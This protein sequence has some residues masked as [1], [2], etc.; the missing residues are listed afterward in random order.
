MGERY[1]W[2]KD[3]GHDY[4]RSNWG[5]S[6][7]TAAKAAPAAASHAAAAVGHHPAPG[8]KGPTDPSQMYL[9]PTMLQHGQSRGVLPKV[10]A[11]TQMSIPGVSMPGM[12]TMK[13]YAPAA[14]AGAKIAYDYKK[15]GKIPASEDVSGAIGKIPGMDTYARAG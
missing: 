15:D 6:K 3:Y 1:Y 14:F 2:E 8:A 13:S 9:D 12:D 5:F 11:A 4:G 10:G 7:T